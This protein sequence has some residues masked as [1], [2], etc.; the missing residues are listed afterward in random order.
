[1]IISFSLGLA[2]AKA[3]ITEPAV[4]MIFFITGMFDMVCYVSMWDVFKRK[5]DKK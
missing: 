3:G 4:F 2:I 5:G 1:M